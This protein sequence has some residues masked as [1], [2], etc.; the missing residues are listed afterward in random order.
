MYHIAE[1]E[2][3]GAYPDMKIPVR[4]I[5][6]KRDELKAK[7][8]ILATKLPDY[9][10]AADQAYKFQKQIRDAHRERKLKKEE[11]SL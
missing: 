9:K 2:L 10:K 6:K 8:S 1:R 4:D 7:Y 11:R 5:A 3:K